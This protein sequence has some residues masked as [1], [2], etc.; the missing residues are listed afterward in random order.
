MSQYLR[1]GVINILCEMMN[2]FNQIDNERLYNTATGK[3]AYPYTAGVL[4]NVN[5]SKC[6]KRSERYEEIIAKQKMQIF[7]T[8]LGRKAIQKSKWKSFRSLLFA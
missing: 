1:H 2:P 4:L 3:A 5:V 6:I 7:E 8:E